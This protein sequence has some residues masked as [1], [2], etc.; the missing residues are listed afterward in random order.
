VS[1]AG[2][3]RVATVVCSTLGLAA[4]GCAGVMEGDGPS[5]MPA[6]LASSRPAATT[7]SH[8][9]VQA[10]LRYVGT[11]YEWGGASPQ[12]FDCSGFV[13]YV[14]G[15]LGVPLPRTVREQ[16]GAGVAVPRERLAVGDVVFFDRLRHNGIYI[17]GGRFVHASRPGD[18]V[19][20]ASL[21]DAWFRRTWIGARRMTG[22]RYAPA[23]TMN[24]RTVA[25]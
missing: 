7:G 10:A 24:S 2:R 14:Y 12:G 21:H 20:I 8:P 17:G 25:R 16:Y 22:T 15:Q 3:R 5:A 18:V 23:P 4:A 6:P 19:K 11:P 1:P 13:Q 9:I